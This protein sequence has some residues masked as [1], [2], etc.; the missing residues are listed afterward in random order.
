[1]PVWSVHGSVMVLTNS[2]KILEV[3]NKDVFYY[4]F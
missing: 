4:L 2:I 3:L 1:M